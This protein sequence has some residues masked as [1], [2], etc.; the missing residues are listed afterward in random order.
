MITF[1]YENMKKKK[2]FYKFDYVDF[3]YHHF[4]SLKYAIYLFIFSLLFKKKKD[5][6]T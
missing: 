6:R 3:S 2:H 1:F 4:M 5:M